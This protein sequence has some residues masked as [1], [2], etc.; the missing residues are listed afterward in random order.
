MELEDK[1]IG[2]SAQ[3]CMEEGIPDANGTYYF[4]GTIDRVVYSNPSFKDPSLTYNVCVFSTESPLPK[5]DL[6]PYTKKTTGTVIGDTIE[7]VPMRSYKFKAKLKE[8][9]D[10]NKYQYNIV[11]VYEMEQKQ[12]DDLDRYLKFLVTDNQYNLIK[13]ECPDFVEKIFEDEN[14]RLPRLK[15]QRQ[16]T[17]DNIHKNVLK[18]RDYV[19][20]IATLGQFP[21]FS[22]NTITKL[23]DFEGGGNKIG[24][25]PSIVLKKI[26]EDPYVLMNLARF[27]WKRVDKLALALKPEMVSSVS[28]LISFCKTALEDI[29]DASDGGHTWILINN[30]ADVKH[31]MAHLIRDNVPECQK[32]VKDYFE[33][34]RQL[35]KSLGCGSMFYVDDERIG[36]AKYFRAE[37]SIL[38]HLNRIKNGEHL[39]PKYTLEEAVKKTNDYMSAKAGE[40]LQLT[41][42]QVDTIQATLDNDV[43]ILTAHAGAGKSTTIKG[44]IELW[45]DKYIGCCALAAKAAIRIKETT[46]MDSYTIH[47]LLGF[48]DGRFT[49]NE[50]CP[51]PFDIVIVDECSM[52]NVNLFLSLLRAVK[53]GGKVILV[54]DDAQLPAIGAGSVAKDLLTSNFCIKRLTK[55]HRQAAKSGIKIDA[56]N[57]RQQIDVFAVGNDYDASGTLP[58]HVTHGEKGDM[59]YYNLYNADAI[60][61]QVM[62]LYKELVN[63][64]GVGGETP[65]AVEDISI[66][67]PMKSNM[68]NCTD[69]FNQE[70]QELL[71]K[72]EDIAIISGTYPD[73]DKTP[74]VFKLGCRVIRRKNDYEKMVFNG[75]LGTI[76]DISD[77]RSCFLVKFD[78]GRIVQFRDK[79]LANFDLAYALTVH[80]MQGSENKAVIFVMDTRH[81]ILL[82]STLFYTAV[83]RAKDMNFVVFQT[84]AYIT[85]YMTD[86][87]LA[88]Q[89]FLPLL[90]NGSVAFDN[91]EDKVE[92]EEIIKED[93]DDDSDDLSF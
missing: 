86:K 40:P 38:Y 8:N 42:E 88:R 45:K 14:F 66:I 25:S 16:E 67:V 78:D 84:N 19:E 31:S 62:M 55:I 82:D 52:I 58:L 90:I 27:G 44:I 69:S 79:E 29:A 61:L 89:T 46:G 51:M 1:R 85:A 22:L 76:I 11:A 17:M 65:I 39:I 3:E 15:G 41:E 75:E 7:L 21:E 33:Q 92:A 43:I 18:Y 68:I 28:R 10:Y 93:I 6:N 32:C 72:D 80:S 5:L 36:L 37:K 20:L 71:L 13:K 59:H 2:H 56:N 73:K 50:E 35:T 63:G 4:I 47:R 9:K 60:H 30:P 34:E 24:N 70:I 26:K 48:K 87:V 53:S 74:R 54:F 77:D 57:I 91:K 12:G 64:G 81:T 83:T 49:Y 23:G